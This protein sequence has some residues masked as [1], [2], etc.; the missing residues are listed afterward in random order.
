MSELIGEIGGWVIGLVIAAII[1]A[2]LNLLFW[3][4]NALRFGR[5]RVDGIALLADPQPLMQR[6]SAATSGAVGQQHRAQQA[7][8][9][10]DNQQIVRLAREMFHADVVAKLEQW[11]RGGR[12]YLFVPIEPKLSGEEAARAAAAAL[13]ASHVVEH[14]TLQ[15]SKWYVVPSRGT[16]RG[17]LFVAGNFPPSARQFMPDI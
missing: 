9:P 6:A 8:A 4:V 1:A 11:N 7:W 10:S 3:G 13:V 16:I 17:Y 15:R 2:L 14:D 12:H 5:E